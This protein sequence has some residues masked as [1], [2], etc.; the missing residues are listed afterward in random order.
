MT[1]VA[2]T[3]TDAREIGDL[4]R[5][6]S[7][8]S[9]RKGTIAVALAGLSEAENEALAATI[10]R[11]YTACGCGQGRVAG[12]VTLVGYV[13]LALTGII[14]VRALGAWKTILLYFACAS[15]A[16]IV[17][18]VFALRNARRSLIALSEQLRTTTTAAIGLGEPHHG[19]HL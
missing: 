13:T 15:V 3:I 14:S 18:K 2:R 19:T 8:L 7:L 10:T 12:I 17:G 5:E 16:M 1:L 4:A 6:V 9:P 11:H